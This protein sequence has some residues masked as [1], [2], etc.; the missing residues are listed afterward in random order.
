[1][2]TLNDIR[3]ILEIEGYKEVDALSVRTSDFKDFLEL[4]RYYIVQNKEMYRPDIL[5]FNV[6]QSTEF[7]WLILLYNDII[8]PLELKEGDRIAI[9][10]LNSLKALL[11]DYRR[12]NDR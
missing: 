12:V 4:E 1:M 10:S 3:K 11:G 2:K 7:W 6:Y 8:D 9:P 5:S